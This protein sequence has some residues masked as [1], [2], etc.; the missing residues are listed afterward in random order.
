LHRRLFTLHLLLLVAQALLVCL[1]RGRQLT[2]LL[3]PNS[4]AAPGA[5]LLEH[6]Q[7]CCA[8]AAAR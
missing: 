6:V 1:A 7:R 5:G 4:T 3:A 8:D 2:V